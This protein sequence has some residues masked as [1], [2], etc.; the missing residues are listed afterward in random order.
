MIYILPSGWLSSSVCET[1]I[2]GKKERPRLNVLT[3]LGK[4]HNRTKSRAVKIRLS[5]CMRLF[6]ILPISLERIVFI[7]HHLK[8]WLCKN[9]KN[10][11]YSSFSPPMLKIKRFIV[12]YTHLSNFSSKKLFIIPLC[13]CRHLQT[14][15]FQRNYAK[16]TR[17]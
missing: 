12:K 1:R 2:Y 3:R 13:H 6:K 17:F 14:E 15:N 4:A 16:Y 5:L 7:K 8:R 10:S 9:V 11:F